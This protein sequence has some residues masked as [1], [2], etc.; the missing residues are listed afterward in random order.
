MSRGVTK[1]KYGIAT[2]A[3]PCGKRAVAWAVNPDPAYPSRSPVCE[4]HS[5]LRFSIIIPFAARKGAGN[6]EEKT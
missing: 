2:S 3:G 1:C 5:G 4:E 6:A